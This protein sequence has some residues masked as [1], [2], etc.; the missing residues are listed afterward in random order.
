[1]GEEV[2]L[3]LF[4]TSDSTFP[5]IVDLQGSVFFIRGISFH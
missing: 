5:S 4:C 2:L 1:M 3:L